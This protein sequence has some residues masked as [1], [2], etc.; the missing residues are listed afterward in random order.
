MT[1][2]QCARHDCVE[3]LPK[4][5]RKF[6]SERCSNVVHV[7]KF[8]A[9]KK[10]P[11]DWRVK[12]VNQPVLDEDESADGRGSMRR[13]PEYERFVEEGGPDLVNRGAT[14][15]Q[16]ADRFGV[17]RVTVT[18]WL[19][20]Y[21]Q[22]LKVERR[23]LGWSP[24]KDAL[25]ALEDPLLFRE[26][27]FRLPSGQSYVTAAFHVRV[28]RALDTALES[29]SQQAVVAPPRHG[30]TEQVVHELVRQI[31]LR[32]NISIAWIGV[33]QDRAEDAVGLVMAEL[34]HNERLIADFCGPGGTFRPPGRSGVSW[35]R[36]EFTVATRT[37]RAKSAT[38][39]AFGRGGRIIGFDADTIVCDDIEDADAVATPMGRAKTL[40]WFRT[41]VASRKMAHTAWFYIGSRQHPEDLIAHLLSNPRWDVI[42]EQAHDDTCVLSER[43]YDAHV[44]CVL[45][46]ELRSFEFLMAQRDSM[47]PELFEMNFLNRPR[48]DGMT[49]FPRDV[50]ED[51]RDFSRALGDIPRD[52][53][54]IVGLDPASKGYQA[55][56]LWAVHTQSN[57]RYL[58]DVENVRGGGTTHL[59]D[60]LE[61]WTLRYPHIEGW[62]I[63]E[64]IVE[65]TLASDRPILE[66]KQRLSIR[67]IPHRTGRNKWDVRLGVP[68]L[69]QHFA[70]KRIVLPYG[71]PDTRARVEPYINQLVNFTDAVTSHQA[72]WRTDLVMAG[73]FPEKT[74]QQWCRADIVTD[75]AKGAYP[76][77]TRLL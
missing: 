67:F 61:R 27:Y 3:L 35:T 33:N 56:I 51:C 50:V 1:A 60:I 52:T 69:K 77:D 40:R 65:D 29:G 68:G 76:W 31:I 53:R 54:L 24:S 25:A 66:L 39:K 5:R 26:R 44:D 16:L 10:S 9:S 49:I 46:P 11:D 70:D 34:E 17:S 48:S 74:I 7:R 73:W 64:N 38:M 63:E 6:C 71:D 59:R 57:T 36:S 22:D 14:H 19:A 75:T 72:Q 30:K 21:R 43:P 32:P 55:A 13:G 18:H 2:V 62:V 20:A 15:Q 37:H 45:V 41:D 42:V 28:A 8:R 58:V 4:G 47:S 12:P 23:R